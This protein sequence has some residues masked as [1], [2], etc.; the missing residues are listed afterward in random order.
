M[1]IYKTLTRVMFISSLLCWD[2]A[3]L[4]EPDPEHT[5]K[6]GSCLNSQIHQAKIFTRICLHIHEVSILTLLHRSCVMSN[7]PFRQ[8]V[9]A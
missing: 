3:I 6:S 9:C 5:H 7:R 8:R 1:Q 4:G 2:F